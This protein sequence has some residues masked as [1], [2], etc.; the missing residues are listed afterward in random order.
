VAGVATN[1]LVYGASG[2]DQTNYSERRFRLNLEQALRKVFT[3]GSA[4]AFRGRVPVDLAVRG[5]AEA[6]AAR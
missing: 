3:A 4:A 6:V 5:A 2:I 1:V